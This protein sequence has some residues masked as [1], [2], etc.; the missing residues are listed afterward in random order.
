MF[1]NLSIAI[2]WFVGTLDK[3]E[4]DIILEDNLP[5]ASKCSK[6]SCALILV[7]K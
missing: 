6:Y 2:D 5:S 1:K 7:I 3:I 4:V